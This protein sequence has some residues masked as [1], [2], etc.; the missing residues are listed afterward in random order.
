MLALDMDVQY[1]YLVMKNSSIRIKFRDGKAEF[2]YD[3]RHATLI[4]RLGG[5]YDVQRASHVEWN[6]TDG[7]YADMGPSGGPVLTGFATRQAA[8]DAEVN[9]LRAN[10]GL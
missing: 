2:I 7:W 4:K 9:W 1:T 3:D 6:P 8:L 5:S 10:K